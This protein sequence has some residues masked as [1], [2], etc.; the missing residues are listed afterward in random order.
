MNTDAHSH[1]QRKGRGGRDERTSRNSSSSGE[2]LVADAKIETP[3]GVVS[4]VNDCP[5]PSACHG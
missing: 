1:S 4:P 5:N 2:A 3:V